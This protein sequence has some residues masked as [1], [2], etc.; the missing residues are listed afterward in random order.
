MKLR[1]R[2]TNCPFRNT[3]VCLFG[4]HWNKVQ[5]LTLIFAVKVASIGTRGYWRSRLIRSKEQ[6]LVLPQL[7][8]INCKGTFVLLSLYLSVPAWVFFLSVVPVCLLLSPWAQMFL[9]FWLNK[10]TPVQRWSCKVFEKVIPV[11]H[12]QFSPS[13]LCP[14][15]INSFT[16]L[17][18]PVLP[19]EVIDLP[20]STETKSFNGWISGAW[21]SLSASSNVMLSKTIQSNWAGHLILKVWWQKSLV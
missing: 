16:S 10:S 15:M 14:L 5:C 21:L 11:L 7:G 6:H 9:L 12:L 20:P 18:D 1:V 2:C 19:A 8:S 17:F 13:T 3:V 4:E